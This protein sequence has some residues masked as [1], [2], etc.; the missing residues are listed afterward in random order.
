MA[1][2]LQRTLTMLALDL[3]CVLVSCGDT[4]GQGQPPAPTDRAAPTT[5][6]ATTTATVTWRHP[7]GA[8]LEVPDGWETIAGTGSAGFAPPGS[9]RPDE[10]FSEVASF[11]FMAAPGIERVS[12]AE[13]WQGADQQMANAAE[14]VERIG[15]PERIELAD[16]AA[17]VL[18]YHTV[19]GTEEGRIDLYATLHDGLAVGL[20]VAGERDR[21]ASD[22]EAMGA[23]FRTL[24]FGAASHDPELVSTW[25][26]G[27]SYVSGEF[28]MATET[29]LVLRRDGRFTRT[30]DAAGGDLGASFDAGDVVD[31]GRWF[32]A[33]G[34]LVLVGDDGALEGW[35]YRRFDGTL[36]LYDAQERRTLWE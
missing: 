28:S 23:L 24:S 29:R 2:T 34:M 32:A 12:Q 36:A 1:L 18:R 19:N 13:F 25:T 16:R 30:A 27:E 5:L 20:L 33:D 14:Q 6:P 35:R 31:G 11:V 3:M 4:P 26:R 8:Q 15:A 7:L 9:K 21:V 22:V 10:R 17:L